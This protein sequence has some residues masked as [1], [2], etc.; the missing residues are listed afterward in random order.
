MVYFNFKFH[1]TLLVL[2]IN[3]KGIVYY[4]ANM[5]MRG[6]KYGHLSLELI[7]LHMF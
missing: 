5:V 1:L 3:S 7:F 6:Q 2:S 4:F